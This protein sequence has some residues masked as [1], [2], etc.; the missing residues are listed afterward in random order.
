LSPPLLTALLAG[1]REVAIVA[2]T[3]LVLVGLSG[4]WRDNLGDA[5]R[6]ARRRL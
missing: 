1:S 3:S 5:D 6:R 2:A 4:I